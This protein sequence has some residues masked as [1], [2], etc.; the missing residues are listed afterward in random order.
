MFAAS[1]KVTGMFNWIAPSFNGILEPEQLLFYQD[2]TTIKWRKLIDGTTTTAL[3]GLTTTR[4][5]SFADLG[6]RLYFCGFDTKGLGTTQ[7][8]INDGTSTFIAFRAPLEFTSFTATDNGVGLC[9]KGLHKI[10]FVFQ[11]SSG[12]SGQPSPVVTAVFT[13]A[14]VTLNAGL[15]TIRAS[16]TFDSPAD[17]GVDSR[18]W[19]IMTRADNPAAWF[20]VPETFYTPDPVMTPASGSA[21]SF[22]VD[23]SISDEDLANRAES[24]ANQFNLLVAGTSSGPFNPGF[25]VAYGKRMCYGVNTKLY[26]SEIDDPQAVTED[27]NVIQLPSQRRIGMAF[28]FGQGLYLTGDKWTGR[29]TDTGDLP[30]TWPQPEMISDCI[31]ATYPGCVEWHTAGSYAW[32]AAE[33]GLYVFNGA[34]PNRPIS[35]LQ[36][37]MWARIN[38]A[39]SYAIQVADDVVS[40]KCYVAVPLDGATEPTHVLVY[41]YTNGL[42]YDTCDFSWY[43]YSTTTFSSIR[44]VKEYTSKRSVL[45]IGPSTAGNVLHA[46]ETTHNDSGAAIDCI[47][48]SGYVRAPGEIQ[49]KTI[50]VGNMDLWMRGSGAVTL[51]WFGL[52]RA[53][54]IQPTLTGNGLIAATLSPLPGIE[55]AAKGDLSP[56][57]NYSVRFRTNAVNAWLEVSGFTGYARPALWVR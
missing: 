44:V 13:P 26:V 5:P 51:S 56:V 34:Y 41:D 20:F 52:D 48:E 7:C 14:S 27:F 11:S 28:P 31:G 29:T 21:Y 36:S 37:D 25:V 16:V 19:P 15:R 18:M 49:S 8:R 38:W 2:G 43:V 9:T 57:E 45:Y 10:G 50:R 55:Y 24:A 40:L 6:P 47:W 54:S 32:V 17:A 1:G 42:A 30:A 3:S 53:L 4:A 12:F 22:T 23:I 35:Y 39:A 33:A 46:D